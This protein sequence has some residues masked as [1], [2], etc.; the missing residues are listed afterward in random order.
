MPK[1]SKTLELSS[2]RIVNLN[3]WETAGQEAYHCINKTLYRDAKIVIFGY[4]ITCK[5]LVDEIRVYWSD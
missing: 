5:K 1:F 2:N 4:D 3:I